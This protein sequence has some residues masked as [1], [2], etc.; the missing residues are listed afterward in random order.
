MRI[1]R[2]EIFVVKIDRHDRFGGQASPPATLVAATTTSRPSGRRSTADQDPE[3]PRVPDHRLGPRG[4]GEGQAPIAPEAAGSILRHL[5][6]PVLL[7]EIPSATSG[8]ATG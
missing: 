1:E 6:A 8:C 3:R 2:I 4:L 7:G 5:L